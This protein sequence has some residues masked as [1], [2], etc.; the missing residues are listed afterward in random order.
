MISAVTN[1]NVIGLLYFVTSALVDFLHIDDALY[2]SPVHLGGGIWGT[3][4]VGLFLHHDRSPV[5]PDGAILYA[6]DDDAFIQF[7]IQC[8]GCVVITAWALA[9]SA[10][11]F[12][13]LRVLGILRESKKHQLE[14]LDMENEQWAYPEPLT[15]ETLLSAENV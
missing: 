13:L 12:F 5:I 15:S 10:G 9:I 11:T 6:W 2:A 1:W 4:A 8:I 14:G 7:G 3:I